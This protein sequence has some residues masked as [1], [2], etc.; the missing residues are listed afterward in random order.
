MLQVKDTLRATVRLGFDGRVY[1]AYHGRD[2]AT[3]FAQE[4]KVL[5][6]LET[7]G[8]KFVPQLL[9][10]DATKHEIVTTNCGQ[11][12]EHLD[13]SRL[14]ELFEELETPLSFLRVNF[15][16]HSRIAQSL[17]STCQVQVT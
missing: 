12:V 13:A 3:R 9:E 17:C 4:V 8:C 10:A 5:R 14:R 1:K 11:R 16:F 7:R 2:A 15:M 6:Y